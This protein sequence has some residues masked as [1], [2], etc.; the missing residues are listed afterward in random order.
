MHL[1]VQLVYAPFAHHILAVRTSAHALGYIPAIEQAI[2][3]IYPIADHI[4]SN[5]CSAVHITWTKYLLASQDE[6]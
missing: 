3:Y 1:N 6:F 5:S 2:S 4:H